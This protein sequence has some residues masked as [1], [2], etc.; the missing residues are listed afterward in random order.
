MTFTEACYVTSLLAAIVTGLAAYAMMGII[1]VGMIVGG[2][3]GLRSRRIGTGLLSLVLGLAWCLSL[4][5]FAVWT[6]G[7]IPTMFGP[8]G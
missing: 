2:W 5:A 7:L 6:I 3:D 8:H 1:G 4:A